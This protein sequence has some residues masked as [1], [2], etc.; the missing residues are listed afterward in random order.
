M[1]F[2][3]RRQQ[4]REENYYEEEKERGFKNVIFEP[5]CFLEDVHF[6]GDLNAKLLPYLFANQV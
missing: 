4:D 5:S 1:T 3:K 2:R 6:G